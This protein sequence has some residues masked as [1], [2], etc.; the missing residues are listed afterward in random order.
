MNQSIREET[1]SFLSQVVMLKRGPEN[2]QTAKAQ[3]IQTNDDGGNK[4]DNF[5]LYTLVSV[6]YYTL[7]MY[8][9]VILTAIFSVRMFYY[10]N[11]DKIMHL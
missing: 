6:L 4:H 9:L 11:V 5:L 8:Y 3:R 1:Y 2:V 10:L 7:G